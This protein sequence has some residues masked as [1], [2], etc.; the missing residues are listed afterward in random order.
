MQLAR[1]H[2]SA[3]RLHY[4]FISHLHGDHYLG[5]MPLLFSMHLHKRTDKLM[6][7]GPPGLDEIITLQLKYS[8]SSLNYP[9]EFVCFDPQ[10]RSVIL[11]DDAIT[12]ETIP[13]QHK[14]PCAGFLFR[15]KTKSLRIDKTKLHAG[16]KLQHI[17]Q[18]K[19]GHD[20]TDEHGQ[21]L[22]R[23]ADYTL[24]PR[25]SRSYAFCSDTAFFPAIVEQISGTDLLYH[26]ATF[27]EADRDKA[28]ET[29]HSTARQAAE[30]ARQAGVKS[31]LIGHFSARYKDLTEV[32]A[33]AT[34][35]FPATKLALEG[36]S[37][38][39]ND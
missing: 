13:L 35:V 10:Q 17:A 3:P 14:L 31:L 20:I 19:E 28:I 2:L 30:I 23:S 18:L 12:V 39:V 4:I 1:F 34:P 8:R 26:E 29:K 16:I 22:Y 32:L 7:F 33:E 9:L 38:T 11:E 21:L 37:F 27:V 24:A 15:E 25:P 5:L 36:E 6:L